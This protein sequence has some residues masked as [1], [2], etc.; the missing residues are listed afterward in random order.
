MEKDCIQVL[1]KFKTRLETLIECKNDLPYSFHVGTNTCHACQV[2]DDIRSDIVWYLSNSNHDKTYH[3]SIY[4]R[5]SNKSCHHD[6]EPILDSQIKAEYS[7]NTLLLDPLKCGSGKWIEPRF[8]KSCLKQIKILCEMIDTL[9]EHNKLIVNDKTYHV[10]F[11][12]LF[13]QMNLYLTRTERYLKDTFENTSNKQ[14]LISL[15][16]GTPYNE[17][18]CDHKIRMRDDDGRLCY[19]SYNESFVTNPIEKLIYNVISTK[20]EFTCELG[21]IPPHLSHKDLNIIKIIDPDNGHIIYNALAYYP[22]MFLIKSDFMFK[23]DANQKR[24]LDANIQSLYDNIINNLTKHLPSTTTIVTDQSEKQ[25][26]L[27]VYNKLLGKYISNGIGL[28]EMIV[29]KQVINKQI[30][31]DILSGGLEYNATINSFTNPE[32]QKMYNNLK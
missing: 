3:S 4:Q 7:E 18:E 9:L 13:K 16:G 1:N 27:S 24:F 11:C 6:L 30:I 14:Q 23:Y 22:S 19:L 10:C 8:G 31:Y 21:Y 17:P 28:P 5:T 32:I 25:I 2:V 15:L 20:L 29:I 26:F 12:Q